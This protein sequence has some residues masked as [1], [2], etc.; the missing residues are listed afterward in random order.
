MGL[1]ITL[2]LSLKKRVQ[3]VFVDAS[4][5]SMLINATWGG[6]GAPPSTDMCIY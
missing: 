1:S 6:G 5:T 4:V 3:A 2:G